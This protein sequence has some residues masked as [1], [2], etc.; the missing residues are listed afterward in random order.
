M[1][2]SPLQRPNSLKRLLQIPPLVVYRKVLQHLC[3]QVL[4]VFSPPHAS[5]RWVTLDLSN[6]TCHNP[7]SLSLRNSP[8]TCK[9]H[10]PENCPFG[11]HTD[12]EERLPQHSSRFPL[13]RTNPGTIVIIR[14]LAAQPI[15]GTPMGMNYVCYNGIK[16]Q[17]RRKPS[18]TP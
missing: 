2:H 8:W 13:L 11:P 17:G 3:D 6:S 18:W 12:E 9:Q 4:C 5:C 10:L 7:R 16:Y 1:Q 15:V 14:C